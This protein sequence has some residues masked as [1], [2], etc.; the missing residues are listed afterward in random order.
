MTVLQ[1]EEI[2]KE[3]E[4]EEEDENLMKVVEELEDKEL[5]NRVALLE[6]VVKRKKEH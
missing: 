6:K 4:D 2:E 3:T 5:L 1:K